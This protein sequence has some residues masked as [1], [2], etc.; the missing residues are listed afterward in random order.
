MQIKYGHI[1]AFTIILFVLIYMTMHSADACTGKVI[2]IGT[3]DT[4]VKKVSAEIIMQL[5]A[6]RTGTKAKIIFYSDKYEVRDGLN[7]TDEESQ[8]DI[9]LVNNLASE[10][11]IT[12][13]KAKMDDEEFPAY[14]LTEREKDYDLWI[15]PD[16]SWTTTSYGYYPLL[17]KKLLVDFPALPRLLNK[18]KSRLSIVDFS[19]LVEEVKSGKKAKNV[20]KDF[21]E[22]KGL[23]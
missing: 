20:A 16:S 5:I 12:F 15:L 6:E 17:R 13:T 10:W 7:T 19:K 3:S 1:T 11:G 4:P 2:V 21:L 22:Y 23:I 14:A 18:I 9:L 8:I